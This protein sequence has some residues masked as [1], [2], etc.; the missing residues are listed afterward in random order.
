MKEYS[1]PNCSSVMNRGRLEPEV[2]ADD[3]NQKKSR[4]DKN[5]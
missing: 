5:T 2:R 4:M 3:G 1:D